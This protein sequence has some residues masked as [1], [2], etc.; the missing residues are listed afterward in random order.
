MEHLKELI[1]SNKTFKI[2]GVAK[3]GNSVKVRNVKI[4]KNN[5]NFYDRFRSSY[6]MH[7]YTKSGKLSTTDCL[8]E[9]SI[10]NDTIKIANYIYYLDPNK[11]YNIV[12]DNIRNEKRKLNAKQLKAQ[13]ELAE[14]G[15]GK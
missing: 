4:N 9:D 8:R 1:N 5:F 12:V 10:R 7:S 2:F 6:I 11:A 3:N 15:N 14:Y 13:I